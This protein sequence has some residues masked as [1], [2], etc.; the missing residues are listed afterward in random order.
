MCWTFVHLLILT[1]L[2]CLSCA[3]VKTKG[4]VSCPDYQRAFGGSCYEFVDLQH[5]FISAQAWCE[6]RGGHLAFIPD[7]ETQ[8]FLQRL[9]DAE[10]DLWLGLAPSATP[11][12]Q[13]SA[14]V[15]DALY[16]LD[17]SHITYSNW[18]SSPQPGAACGH[19][20]RDSG[21][22]WE[23]TRDC[24]KKL[25]FICQFESGR[26]I[27][28]S[29]RNTSLQC[30][31]GQVLMIDGGLYGRKNIHYCRSTLAPPITPTGHQCGWVDVVE[32][33]TAH[34]HGHQVCQIA[35]VV[36]SFGEPCP[37]L[38]S[39][40]SVDHHCKDGLTLSVSTAAAVFDE[41][42]ISVKW[43]LRDPH[44]NPS[45]KMSTGDGRVIY[46]HSPE[47]FESSEVHKYTHP[48]TFVVAVEC[49]SRDIHITAQST[50]TIQEPITVFGVI[51]CYAGKL[52]FNAN[53]CT[54]VTYRIQCD[55]TLLLGLSVFRGNVPQ[56]ITVTPEMM[57]QLGPGC[58]QLTLYASNMVTYPEVS[59]DLQ[60]CV[61][62]KVAGLQASVL[63][64]GDDYLYSPDITVGVSLER[65][66]PVLLLFSLTG[67]NSSY[68]EVREM[69]TSKDIF[70]IAH[71]IQ[72]C[73]PIKEKAPK[74]K[75]DCLEKCPEI[76]WN[77][78][79]PSDDKDWQLQDCSKK[80]DTRPIVQIQ[81][82][83][84]QYTVDYNTLATAKSKDRNVNVVITSASTTN[85]FDSL[86]CSI[87][88][89]SGTI[90]NF[91]TITCNTEMPCS[92]CQYC[93]KTDNG[94]HLRCSNSNEV[95]S[96]FLPLGDSSSNFNMIITATAKSGSFV[97]STTITAKVMD[98]TASTLDDVKASVEDAVAQLKKEGLLSAETVGQL[99]NS[100]S[101]EL[102]SQSDESNKA[103]R[104]KLREKML[105]I[106][107]DT[108]KEA[109]TNTP[110]EVQ[111]IARG[112]AAVVQK[113]T[114]LSC[115]AQEEASLLLVNLSSYLLRMDVNTSEENMNEI[116]AAA[117]TIV[118]GV[119]NIL[120][121]SCNKNVSDALL[122]SLSNTMSAL[123]TFKDANKA[124]TIIQQAHIGVFVNRVTLGRLQ[125]EVVKISNSSSP[126][127]SLPTLPSNISPSDEPVDVRMLSL[128]K[129]P[130]S[131]NE[132]GNISGQI[133]S[134]S[135]T[136]KDGASIPV[137]N[138]SEDIKILIPRPVGEQVNTSF[139][140]LGN[141]STM[142]INIPSADTTLVLKMVPSSDPLPFKLF[143][144]HMDYPTETNNVAM[145]EMP[146]QGATQEERYTWLLDP[147][148]LK[149][150]NGVHYLVVRPIVGPGIKSINASLSITSFTAACKFW[151][152][153]ILEWSPFGCR[154][155][156]QTTHSVTQC[157][158]NHLSFFGGSF[159]VTPNLVDASRTAELFGTFAENPVVVCFVGSLFGAYLLVVMWARRKDIQDTAKVKVTVLEDN[160]PIDEYRYLLSVS[161]GHRR[162]AFTSTQ[163]TITLLGAEG[164]SEP[165]H[166][167][168]AKKCV[169]ERG[170]LDFFLLTTPL[171]LG[172]LQGIRLW[173]NNSG[174]HPAWYVGNVMVHDIQTEQKW[175]F[176]CNSWLAIDIGD[177]C[178]DKVV[179]VSTEMDLKRFSNLFFM[180]TTKDFNDGHL[181]YSVINRPPSSNFTCV[182]RVSCCFT[183]LL[184]TMLT[185][186]MFY[187]I[188]TDPSEQTMDLGQFEFSWQQFMIGVQSS[189]IMFPINI[190]IV[191]IFRNTRP[192]ET[193][194]CKRK[195][196]NP[197]ALDQNWFSQT[198][199]T[200]TNV[201]V[202]LDTVIKDISRIAHSLSKT[203]KSN[204]PSTESEFGPGQQVDI[205]AVLSVVEDFIKPNNKTPDAAQPKTQS[206]GNLVQ[207]QLPEGSPGS[208]VEG[209]QKKSNKT[210]YLYRQLCH[211][212]K[213][214]SLLGPSGFPNPHSYSQA[215]QQ[216]QGIK[217]F[218][219]NQ[220]FTVSCVNP[221]E[222]TENE[223]YSF[224]CRLSA[225][226]STDGDGSKKKRVCCHGGLPWWF[227]FVG[228]LLVIASS[229]VSGYYTML[230]G[231]KFGKE[232]SVS[233]L[234]SM[235]V[236]FFQ[237]VLV[238]QP[239]KV[240]CVAVFFALVIKKVD[241]EDFQN[242][243]FEGNLGDCKDQQMVRRDRS[244]Y[245]PPPAADIEKMR[246]KQIMEQKAFALLKEI[247]TYMGFMW[248]LLLV[249]YG[250]R[251]PNAFFLNRHI[252]D[253]FSGKIS[254]S[255]S[256]GD[257][258]TWANTSLL[259]NL[260]GVYPGYIT[261]GNS[262]LVGNAR[263][264]QLRVQRNSCEIAGP[265][266]QL[267]PDCNAPFSWEVEDMGSYDTGWNHSVRD[268]IST[269]ASSPWT[270]QTQS[271]LRAYPIWGKMVLYRGGGYVAE[272]GPDSQNAS[273]TLEYLFRNTWLDIYTRAVFVEF[274]VYNAN[275]NLF[276]IVTLLLETTVVGAFQLHSELQSVRLYQSTGGL[277]IF[278][279]TAEIIYLL[280]IL[281]YMFLQGKLMK[282]QRC[283]YFRSKWNLLELTIISLSWSAVAVFTKRTLLGDR[284]M[285]YYQNHKDQFASFYETATAD[286]V[287][288]YLIAFLVLLAT[289]KLWHLLRLNPKMNLITAALQRAW[290]D[291]SSFLVVIVIMFVAYSIAC[292][293]IYGWKMSSYRTLTD[294]LVT[295]ISLQIG[296]FNY[297][298]V[299]DYNPVLGGLLFGSCIVFMTFVVLNLFLSVILVAFKQE[300]IHHKPSDEEEIVDLMLKNIFSVFG[301]RYEDTKDT[302]GPD[303]NE[304]VVVSVPCSQPGGRM[305]SRW[306]GGGG[307]DI[308]LLC[309]HP[310]VNNTLRY[311]WLRQSEKVAGARR[312]PGPLS[313]ISSV[314]PLGAPLGMLIRGLGPR[315]R[316]RVKSTLEKGERHA[317]KMRCMPGFTRT[318]ARRGKR[319]SVA[320]TTY[321]PVVACQ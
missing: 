209:I 203:V 258:F 247:L 306:V 94:I 271:Q 143:L 15:E 224:N 140:D 284:D 149:G 132:R 120:D 181:W 118:E 268:N 199:T 277:H 302:R 311:M 238:I 97:W 165:H 54:N 161:T 166:L 167:A 176:L 303:E 300:Q 22:K 256:L 32:S 298:E 57:R 33:L 185:S 197:D 307:G 17:G 80:A 217:G 6:Q 212:D 59:T 312:H 229:F 40:L 110:E 96:V 23:A 28:C 122:L 234:V 309:L 67:D 290:N 2:S 245:E 292:N 186:I 16:W 121:Y 196:K 11:N 49:T 89:K 98:S 255:M 179:P 262:K 26:S 148:D 64:E 10:K 193:S 236:S 163:V 25:H 108:V 184:C 125:T 159:F 267:A 263:L 208:T 131:W 190:L 154:V 68:S 82:I 3:E 152:E 41:V 233:W 242:V 20:L 288:Q 275:V 74:M 237:S 235:I 36:G 198:T 228:W 8:Y 214:L 42:T 99:I 34:C 112:L 170:A 216:V 169:F 29:G 12:L 101:N 219:Q 280:F 91:F 283:A 135:L 164:N 156:V 61:L 249:A 266:L 294:A 270:Y 232:R 158:C 153:S 260:F 178:L 31:S 58:H 83:G 211:I 160:D 47:G 81:D 315:R 109:P 296:I 162:G 139:L 115:S 38:G 286:S 183:L 279:M 204:I 45:C 19:T 226:D 65:G 128:D 210:Q 180:K 225:A 243:E 18:V 174:S 30:G 124:P 134:L 201:N 117:S 127:F 136:R 155:G 244:L 246:R 287:L 88:P 35:E 76:V 69:N 102:N 251:D 195:T 218:L 104:Q 138:L 252:R 71:P 53:N 289:F 205:N 77:I 313:S 191:S 254:D 301:I 21:F 188:P 48:S 281:Y 259:S 87:S 133:G 230:F 305:E 273:S 248:M 175:H 129:N 86:K 146:H 253:S 84:N 173:H 227:L 207:P 119:S 295:V 240:L 213:E 150:N 304:D 50:I 318:H 177:C 4:P 168:D 194:C 144:G 285:T 14:T 257:V 1:T 261:D 62:E 202:T 100:V 147:T 200:N 274:T 151:D 103:D 113:G 241:E 141:Y 116:N 51:R 250:Q 220:L 272:L 215:L 310:L 44:G 114:E 282:Q 7:E 187:G 107:I 90:L 320:R 137:E 37:Q 265:M 321:S 231:L 182:Q 221:D 63:T 172:D 276:C 299:M 55:E 9:S 189:L 130:F 297:D 126:S 70:R 142:V 192:R 314:G 13:Y 27:M 157:L 171:P 264:R 39:Y 206:F 78:E 46:L 43:L 291:I 123:L 269:S 72:G 52:S 85:N 293:V 95:K 56:N 317:G 145:T 111:V 319:T 239:L 24:N 278:V 73:E 222:L 223:L 106:M 308:V 79:D 92:N 66:V 60:M 93:F 75:M 316:H 105:D 5:S